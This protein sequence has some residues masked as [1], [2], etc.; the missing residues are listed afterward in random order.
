MGLIGKNGICNWEGVENE[1]EVTE[2]EKGDWRIWKI[3]KWFCGAFYVF[4]IWFG[5]VGMTT[6]KE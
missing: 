6:T 5:K 4:G 1:K 2:W 3:W